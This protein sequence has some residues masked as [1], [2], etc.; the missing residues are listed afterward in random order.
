MYTVAYV[1]VCCYRGSRQK[2]HH[3]GDINSNQHK[4]W[5]HH[6]PPSESQVSITACWSSN[7]MKIRPAPHLDEESKVG[8]HSQPANIRG[9][10]GTQIFAV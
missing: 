2:N 3:C 8:E 9:K 7:E 6:T 10:S 1:C 5:S 4:I